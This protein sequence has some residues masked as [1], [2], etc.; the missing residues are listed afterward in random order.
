M[1]LGPEAA[2]KVATDDNQ[3]L[4]PNSQITIQRRPT[5]CK[6]SCTPNGNA[7]HFEAV[8][9]VHFCFPEFPA[10]SAYVRTLFLFLVDWL[11]SRH[12]PY[13]SQILVP[14]REPREGDAYQPRFFSGKFKKRFLNRG[15]FVIQQTSIIEAKPLLRKNAKS[16]KKGE[17][18]FRTAKENKSNG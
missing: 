10:G 2:H 3:W 12:R 17:S 5:D 8:C 16:K 6:V 7:L 13:L 15:L 14:R 4:V 18:Y 9:P 11:G 1:W